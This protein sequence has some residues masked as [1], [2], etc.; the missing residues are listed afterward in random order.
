[1]PPKQ[2]N[3]G[4]IGYA[5]MGKAHSQA[6][7]DVAM[8]FPDVKLK[9]VMKAICGRDETAVK[10]AAKLYG[11]ESYETDANRLI[12][13]DDIDVVDVSSPGWARFR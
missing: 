10:A 8:Y 11:W 13:R 6:F 4:L 1:M 5:F 3:V 9:P 7:R 12:Q 2:V